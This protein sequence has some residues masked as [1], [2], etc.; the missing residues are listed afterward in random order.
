MIIDFHQLSSAHNNL[1]I[2]TLKIKTTKTTPPPQQY[3][4]MAIV[5]ANSYLSIAHRI[6]PDT[7]IYI[8]DGLNK[9]PKGLYVVLTKRKVLMNLL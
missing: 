4:K 2:S 1:G 3:T 8:I 6:I 7:H 9:E 5:K